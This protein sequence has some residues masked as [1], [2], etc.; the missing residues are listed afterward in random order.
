MDMVDRTFDL[1]L[2]KL[3]YEKFKRSYCIDQFDIAICM[4]VQLTR[5]TTY[6]CVM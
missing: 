5:T 4:C 3:K 1:L 6:R 2:S